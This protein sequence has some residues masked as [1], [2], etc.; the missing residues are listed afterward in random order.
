MKK[1]NLIL[2]VT[3][4]ALASCEKETIEPT[5]VV[6]P[7]PTVTASEYSIEFLAGDY[8]YGIH[9]TDIVIKV[10]GDSI[11]V[12]SS[13]TTDMDVADVVEYYELNGEF[14]NT[15]ALSFSANLG[16]DYNIEAFTLLGDLIGSTGSLTLK[17]LDDADFGGQKP[18]LGNWGD[19]NENPSSPVGDNGSDCRFIGI[20]KTLLLIFEIQ[21]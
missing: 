12:L 13:A 18:S 15:G 7:T 11:G 9:Y 5:P 4:L 20:N 17:L 8:Y 2:A 14:P 16:T 6:E 21:E 19:W 3:F 1:Y 10:N